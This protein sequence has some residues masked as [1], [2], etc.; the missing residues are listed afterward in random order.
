MA[1]LTP[2]L[3]ETDADVAALLRKEAKRQG[4]SIELIASENFV[5]EAVLEAMG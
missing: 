1:S 2:H 5:S 3:D 4:L